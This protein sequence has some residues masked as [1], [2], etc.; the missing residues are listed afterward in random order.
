MSDDKELDSLIRYWKDRLVEHRLLMSPP[1]VYQIEQT[2]TYLEEL[3]R[4]NE[5]AN[6]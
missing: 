5:A 4:I 1:T 6:G 2:I 3:K